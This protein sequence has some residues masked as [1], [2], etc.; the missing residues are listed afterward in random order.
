MKRMWTFLGMVVVFLFGSIAFATVPQL[1]NFQGIL[2]DGSGNPVGDGSYSV[3]FT[4][5]DDPAAGA[6]LWAET[7]SVSTS[8][9][10]F[11][12]LLGADNPVPDSAFNDS[13][14]YLGIKVGA[15]PEMTPRQKMASVGYSFRTEQ[16]TSAAQNLLRMNGNVG[17]GTTIPQVKLHVDSG[18]VFI[19]NIP[20]P[21]LSFP[22]ENLYIGN[23]IGDPKNSFR[24]DGWLNDLAIIASSSPG[25]AAGAS[26]SF[27]TALAGGLESDRMRISPAGNIGIG[28]NA[29]VNKLDVEGGA[30]IGTSFSGTNSAPANGLLVQGNVGIGTSSPTAQLHVHDASGTINGSRLML[31]Q[32]TTG[33]TIF[34]GAALICTA[35]NRT[36]LWNYENG[37]S[38]FGTNNAERLRI[39][40]TGRVGIGI[41]APAALLH[42]NGTAGNN[43][44]VWSNLS[45]RRLKKEI[46]P[47]SVALESVLQLKGVTFRWKDEG[48]DKE[49]GRVRGLIAQDVEQV[50]PE[51]VKTDPDGYKRLEPIGIDALL[52]EA[53]KEQQKQIEELKKEIRELKNQPSQARVEN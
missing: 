27:R 10:L 7:T 22:N 25:A 33:T 31:T 3:I 16:W 50:I 45:D 47:V 5:Y 11:T 42:V 29:P 49:F 39:D 34:D 35:P 51:W 19:G 13:S 40:S 8:D 2:K 53:I 46:E 14:R 24:I 48:M 28:T 44:G 18:D 41:S 21:A 30:A 17:I 9:G 23:T 12:V 38:I 15:D 52:I 37:P 4:I 6:T 43:T 36:Y 1:I 32:T 20:T 26:I